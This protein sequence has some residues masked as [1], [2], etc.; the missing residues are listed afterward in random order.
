M[1]FLRKDTLFTISWSIEASPSPPNNVELQGYCPRTPS[2]SRIYYVLLISSSHNNFVRRGRCREIAG[3][4]KNSSIWPK[5]TIFIDLE[6]AKAKLCLSSIARFYDWLDEV[7]TFAPQNH[8]YK[9]LF[10]H[11]EIWMK[12]YPFR[13]RISYHF[14]H[15]TI[16]S[17]LTVIK[18]SGINVFKHMHMHCY[19]SLLSGY[20]FSPYKPFIKDSSLRSLKS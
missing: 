11:K 18:A 19:F 17:N 14:A 20:M 1:P 16:A 5:S 7:K 4:K 10:K 12:F 15:Q 6:K 8:H 9:Y 3:P 2:E 13:G